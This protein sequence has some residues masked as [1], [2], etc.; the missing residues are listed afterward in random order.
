MD[1]APLLTTEQAAAWLNTD[2]RALYWLSYSGRGPKRYKVGRGYR[3]K[4]TDLADWLEQQA[5]QPGT[6]AS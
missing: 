5:V 1:K 6:K 3:Y 2:V 4:E